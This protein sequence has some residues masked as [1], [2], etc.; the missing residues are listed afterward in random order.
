MRPISLFRRLF[1]PKA[2]P[3]VMMLLGLAACVA[4][5]PTPFNEE[6]AA[7]G[8][9]MERQWKAGTGLNTY[10]DTAYFIRLTG[11][12]KL[13]TQSE[14]YHSNFYK[15]DQVYLLNAKPGRYVVV[16]VSDPLDAYRALLPRLSG[17]EVILLKASRGVALEQVIPLFEHDF[18]GDEAG[19]REGRS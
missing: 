19:P 1:P 14:L 5:A 3:W 17:D 4:P 6:S 12:G 8:L 2:V 7:L 13:T 10:P 11:N 9:S 16:A 15:D 18:G